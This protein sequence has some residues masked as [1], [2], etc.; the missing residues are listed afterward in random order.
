MYKMHNQTVFKAFAESLKHGT[1]RLGGVQWWLFT[2]Q[3]LH[4]MFTA[5]R[6]EW[7]GH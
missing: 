3:V 4:A 7:E 6:C 2:L 5:V 1:Y